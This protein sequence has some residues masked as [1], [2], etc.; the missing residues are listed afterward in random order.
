[1]FHYRAR[2]YMPDICRFMTRDPY[3]YNPILPNTI[4]RY[5]YCGNSAVNFVDP[6]G[7]TW[8]WPAPELIPW[9]LKACW[10]KMWSILGSWNAL[11]ME[12]T[13]SS[14]MLYGWITG[15]GESWEQIAIRFKKK[16]VVKEL[17]S[18][19]VN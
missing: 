6:W 4:Q 1:M 16:L 5:N 11:L 9:W 19:N 13:Y 14:R 15:F 8:L 10:P 18:D 3:P 2:N 7:Y 17:L 12:V